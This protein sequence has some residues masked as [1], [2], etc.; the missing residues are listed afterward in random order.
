MKS[1]V[2]LIFAVFCLITF[3]S[4]IKNNNKEIELFVYCAA[5][6]KTPMDNIVKQYKKEYGVNV[7]VQYGGSGSLLSSIRVS[8]K[9]D[10]YLASDNS[11]LESAKKYNLVDEIQSLAFLKPV[12]VTRKGNPKKISTILDFLKPNVSFCLGTPDVTSI[13]K[14]TQK[15]Y[16]E[17]NVWGDISKKVTVFKPTVFDVANDVKLGTVDAAIIWD[18]VAYQYPELEIIKD[19][20]LDKYQESV[21]V[22]VLKSS[23]NPTEALKFLRYLSAKD[24]G[25]SVFEKYKY[26]VIE[27]DKW[28]EKPDLLLYSGGVNRVAV[29]AIIKQFEAREGL[30]VT[31]VYNG[32]GILVGQIKTGRKPDAFLTCDISFMDQVKADFCDLRNISQTDIVIV[33][34][35][36]NPLN[37]KSLKDLSDQSLKLGVGNPLQSTLGALTQRIFKSLKLESINK[38]VCVQTPTA[39]LLINQLRTGALD[40]AIVYKANTAKVKDKLD[41]IAIKETYAT[42]TQN[43]GLSKISEN[44]NAMKRLVDAIKSEPSQKYFINNG[45]VIKD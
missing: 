24:K 39:D 6:M 21:W 19:T 34:K 11:F 7:I 4:C 28:S 44:K 5:G 15:L 14:M 26:T 36:G 37:I 31:R 16:T 13:G 20:Q 27:G 45:F 43:F 25:L 33:T 29:E 22:T 10:I 42:A 32:C 18:G 17:L 3:N 12:I 30:T 35:K 41:V 1:I 38:N 2:V 8:N 40:A 9:G 23:K